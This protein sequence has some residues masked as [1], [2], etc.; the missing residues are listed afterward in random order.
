MNKTGILAVCLLLTGHLSAQTA[1]PLDALIES[2]KKAWVSAHVD[3]RNLQNSADNRSDIRY[4]R[5]HWTVDPILKFIQGEV[6]TVFEPLETLNSLAFDFSQVLTMDSIRFHGQNLGFLRNGD[7]IT[8]QFPASL[9]AFLPDSLQFFY[10]G[11]PTS[12]GFGSFEVNTHE[13]APVLWTLS[14]PYGAMEW[15]PCKQSLL[16]KIDSIDVFITHPAQY[17]AASNGLLQ[18][19]TSTNGWTTAH[20]KHRYP[21]AA[22]L[23][24]MAVSNY[25]V[26]SVDAPFGA[27]TT[28]ILNYVYPESLDAAQ[29]GVEESVA[30]MQLYNQLFGLYPFQEEKYGH[31][32]F[33]WGGGME[34]QTMT[35]VGNFGYDLLVHELAHQWFGDKVT[36][37][38]WQDIWLNEGF[39]TYLTGLCYNFLRP[40]YWEIY[41][42]D[43]IN[44][45]TLEPDGSV[46]VEDT[47]S[48]SRV[49][50]SRLTYAKGAMLLHMLRWKMGDTAFFTGVRNYINDPALVYG[51]A[52][53]GQLKAHL[54]ASSGLDLDEFFAD[55]F[56]G[57]GFPSYQVSWAKSSSNEVR[58]KLEQ[59]SSNASVSFFEMP[60][61]VKLTDEVHDTILVLDHVFSGQIF[62][63]NLS[64]SPTE[65]IFD[66]ELWLL[67]RNNLIQEEGFNGLP[68][69]EISL[70]VLPNPAA[71]DFTLRIKTNDNE[72][73]TITLWSADGKQVL[74]QNQYLLPGFNNVTVAAATL[75]AGAYALR[76]QTRRWRTERSVVLY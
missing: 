54:E 58:I 37:A 71:G 50:S 5:M 61:D 24:C 34:H 40:Q 7:V 10:Q 55:W 15:W 12:T 43:R 53:T 60:V 26:F 22:Y 21:I 66:P 64:F 39:A 63:A 57:K 75:P 62:S 38:S 9:P 69:P 46:W 42:A 20:W 44:K 52:R 19:E 68:L 14:E 73:A 33:G 59:S 29:T 76:V 51:Y 32:Q 23:V 72:S 31:T 4:C 16:D 28:K 3:D 17:K 35:F 48:V 74:Q 8:V 2:E 30:A 27:D 49:F 6:M 36:C 13:G 18:S 45:A 70:D 41:K 67:S 65:L 1:D 25:E 11:A 56:Y 47:S